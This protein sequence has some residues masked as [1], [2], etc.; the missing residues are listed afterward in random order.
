MDSNRAISAT[1]YDFNILLKLKKVDLGMPDCILDRAK[2]HDGVNIN[3]SPPAI[4]IVMS[5][6]NQQMYT[7]LIL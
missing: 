3:P 2:Q 7:E 4:S 6:Y 5:H 1:V